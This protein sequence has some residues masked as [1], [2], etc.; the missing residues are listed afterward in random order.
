MSPANAHVCNCPACPELGLGVQEISIDVGTGADVMMGVISA[1]GAAPDV[2]H[3][4]SFGYVAV[5]QHV[6]CSC[7]A[8]T[9]VG[10]TPV[11]C[12]A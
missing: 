11:C 2:L 12:K 9:H 5:M 1:A 7:T 3:C 8:A 6:G 10:M 4:Q